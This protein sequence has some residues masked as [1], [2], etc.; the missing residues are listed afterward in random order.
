MK[1]VVLKHPPLFCVGVSVMTSDSILLDWSLM[2]FPQLTL[3]AKCCECMEFR[4]RM[5]L[6]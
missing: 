5:K 1:Q 4:S 2:D 6:R 3:Y